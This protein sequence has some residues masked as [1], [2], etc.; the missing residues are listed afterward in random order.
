MEPA[1]E[2]PEVVDVAAACGQVIEVTDELAGM[3]VMTTAQLDPLGVTLTAEI[4]LVL[5]VGADVH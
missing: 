5:N 4:P 2:V 3:P 1:V